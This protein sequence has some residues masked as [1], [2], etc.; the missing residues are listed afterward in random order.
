MHKQ[1][2]HSSC[3]LELK[4]YF[5]PIFVAVYLQGFAIAKCSISML[6]MILRDLCR[7]MFV[8]L[9]F[10]LGFSTGKIKLG[11]IF[12]VILKNLRKLYFSVDL[13]FLFPM[14]N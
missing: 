9:V 1:P 10:L 8:Y 5:L 6:Q 13:E 12:L 2:L 7:F 4:V 3:L 14:K 11:V